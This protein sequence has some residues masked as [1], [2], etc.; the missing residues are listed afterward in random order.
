[1]AFMGAIYSSARNVAACIGQGNELK[2]LIDQHDSLYGSLMHNLLASITRKAYFSRIWVKQEVILAREVGVYCGVDY[3]NWAVVAQAVEDMN[4]RPDLRRAGSLGALIDSRKEMPLIGYDEP[5]FNDRSKWMQ[6]NIRN[7]PWLSRFL[8]RCY[9]RVIG[10]ERE[11]RR[12]E[13]SEKRLRGLM[14]K[15]KSSRAGP[16]WRL[17]EQFGHAQ[18]QDPRDKIYALLSL[19]PRDSNTAFTCPIDYSIPLPTLALSILDPYLEDIA[20]L[21]EAALC[22]GKQTWPGGRLDSDVSAAYC[23]HLIPVR[24][25]LQVW[26]KLQ[27][28]DSE[29]D[30]FREPPS[31]SASNPAGLLLSPKSQAVEWACIP[32]RVST[33]LSLIEGDRSF[34]QTSLFATLGEVIP[35][36]NLETYLRGQSFITPQGLEESWNEA[37]VLRAHFPYLNSERRPPRL[38][39]YRRNN[40]ATDVRVVSWNKGRQHKELFVVPAHTEPHDEL[41]IC[42]PMRD[43]M[44]GGHLLRYGCIMP[45]VRPSEQTSLIGWALLISPSTVAKQAHDLAYLE[46]NSTH[47]LGVFRFYIRDYLS[48]VILEHQLSSLLDWRAGPRG[49][50]SYLD[51]ISFQTLALDVRTW[52]L[53][54][55]LCGCVTGLCVVV[56]IV[57]LAGGIPLAILESRK[58]NYTSE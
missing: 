27:S 1:M 43:N 23:T 44:R 37:F 24:D 53:S 42:D 2:Q 41:L 4:N 14:N 26:F 36:N 56:V 54:A 5:L 25:M 7:D 29:R 17:L 47:E 10:W 55:S 31:E 39:S 40:V 48:F 52:R 20:A 49:S 18:C 45:I 9:S 13:E 28:I 58:A 34:F 3:V 57:A 46:P 22:F 33:R 11:A 21:M 19:L 15:I 30:G 6:R 51:G 35:M 32:M 12:N 8:V 38:P 16:L 50:L